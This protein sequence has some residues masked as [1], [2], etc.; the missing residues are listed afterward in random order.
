MGWPGYLYTILPGDER[1]TAVTLYLRDDIPREGFHLWVILP[2]KMY[3]K[4]PWMLDESPVKHKIL[5]AARVV[6]NQWLP[7][8]KW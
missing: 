5:E 6:C 1:C 2:D 4:N 3:M 7:D 8:W